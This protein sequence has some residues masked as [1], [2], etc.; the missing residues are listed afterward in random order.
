VDTW[1]LQV[2][3][4]D[5]LISAIPTLSNVNAQTNQVQTP[6]SVVTYTHPAI[7]GSAIGFR[8][9]VLGVGGPII[10]S[11][12][13]YTRTV[14]N[15]RVG[16]VTE[17]R[18]GNTKYGWAAKINPL[19]RTGSL[20]VVDAPHNKHMAA[21][22]TTGVGGELACATGLTATPHPTSTLYISVNGIA[23]T[24]IGYGVKTGCTCYWSGDGGVTSRARANVQMNDRLYWNS[25]KAEFNLAATDFIDFW[26]D[27]TL[28]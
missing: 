18:E 1:I 4:T 23:I 7:Q 26:Y 10:T 21:L 25:A 15:T 17:T 13:V 24:D 6:S 19:I 5:E 9:E 28:T 11:F 22:P 20:T 8:S 12:G 16:F 14:F 27:V 3:G 2:T